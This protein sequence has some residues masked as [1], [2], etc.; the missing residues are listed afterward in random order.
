MCPTSISVKVKVYQQKLLRCQAHW[1]ETLAEYDAN[2][3]YVPGQI[4]SAP[5]ALSYCLM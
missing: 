4:H 5:G 3:V 1:L 2:F